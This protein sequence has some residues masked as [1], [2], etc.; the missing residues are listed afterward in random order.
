MPNIYVPGYGNPTAKLAIVGEAP[1]KHEEEQL[2][3]F[4]GP[5]GNILD[6]CLE[7]AG[8]S[9]D[10]I[11]IT[12]VVKVRPPNNKIKDLNLIGHSIEEFIPQL[13]L[14][15]N[16]L[17]PNCIL[18]VGNTALEVLTGNKGIEKY[19]GSI[20]HSKLTNHKIVASLHPASLLHEAGEG[21]KSWK[22]LA[23]IRHDI[24]RA[25]EQS[26]FP[27]IRSPART[28]EIARNSLDVYRFFNRYNTPGIPAFVDVET[29]KTIPVCIGIAFNSWHA[30]SIPTLDSNIPMHDLEYTWKMLAEF[31]GDNKFLLGA[32]NGKFDE[33]RCRQIG[34]KW[35]D[36]YFDTMLAWHTLF[37][38]FPKK[39]AV[40]S[41][42]LT[43]E[44]YYKD[45]G[46]EYIPGKHNF[47]RLLSYN[48]KDAVIEFECYEKEMKMLNEEPELKQFF[49]DKV[50]PLHRLYSN[51]EDIGILVDK[52]IRAQLHKKYSEMRDAKYETLIKNIIDG[53][54]SLRD[55]IGKFNPNS[56]KQVANLLYGHLRCPARKDTGEDTLKSL[57]NN[58][59]KDQ[60][61]KDIIQGI[62]EQRKIRKTIGTYLEANTSQDNRIR[63]EMMIVGTESGRTSTQVR[64]APIVVTQEGLAL[65]T[66]T[67][68]ED[69]TLDAGG[70]DLRSM[71]IA[72]EGYSFTEPDLSQAEDRV[73]CLLSKD[74]DALKLYEKTKFKRNKYGLKDDRH[75]L[76]AMMVCNLPFE[77]VTDYD[78]QIG[79]RVR[80][81]GNYDMGK[82]QG[83]LT[84]AK[85][86]IFISE[87]KMGRY[88]EAFHEANSKIKSVFHAEIQK[89][90][91]TQQC[92]LYSPHGRKRQ[93]FNKWGDELFKE[94]YSYIPQATVSDQLKF[95]LLRIKA[96]LKSIFFPV[97]ESHDSFLALIKDEFIKESVPII[98]RELEVPINF[99]R[100]TLSRNYDLV[101]P[102]EIKVGKRWID[103][104]EEFPDG[105]DKYVLR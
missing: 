32:Q 46:S 43:E 49:F 2:R 48:A 10:D 84:L 28:L 36:L 80:H 52:M 40:I 38:E 50:M 56:P 35:Y 63:T 69:V 76:T 90:L 39:L 34:L 95:A 71:F 18:A 59:I 8:V 101:I 22:D 65:Q 97:L 44:P 6:E 45:E 12:N 68:H 21:M 88:L 75:T 16:E 73:V 83:M 13:V 24:K 102:C 9:R 14:E 87:W 70:A 61:R 77:E 29:S 4:V 94:A 57:A 15:L 55:A 82:H 85:F 54:E 33:K 7:S 74:Y 78:R 23:L 60:R 93:F 41:S 66:M 53:D 25:V 20:L 51:M 98:K 67:K 72:D 42:I 86:G 26:A 37:A 31:L 99:S 89:T 96:I 104:S 91:S 105:M 64:K 81:A 103:K 3:P 19:R 11:Y 1:G 17:N 92:I 5:S 79:K 100:C 30:I 47:D 58:S 27:E 62:L